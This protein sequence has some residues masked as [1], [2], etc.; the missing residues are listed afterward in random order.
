M[1][2]L[3]LFT[4]A[5]EIPKITL[6]YPTKYILQL[7]YNCLTEPGRSSYLGYKRQSDVTPGTH[8]ARK[9]DCLSFVA[10]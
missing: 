4:K 3:I 1:K 7:Q 9:K 10:K 6:L 8:H 2:H 5:E